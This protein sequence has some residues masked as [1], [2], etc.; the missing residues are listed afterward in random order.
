MAVVVS[1]AFTKSLIVHFFVDGLLHFDVIILLVKL[2]LLIL[3][4]K[5]FLLIL[6]ASKV[7][8]RFL[9]EGPLGSC[10]MLSYVVRAGYRRG[11][12]SVQNAYACLSLA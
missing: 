2:F 6:P 1:S 8:M 4:A 11:S 10:S 9:S 12:V 7:L 5:L 3:L